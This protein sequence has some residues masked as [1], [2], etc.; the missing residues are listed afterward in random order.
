[1]VSHLTKADFEATL[2]RQLD[3]QQGQ[4]R[5]PLQAIPLHTWARIGLGS[6]FTERSTLGMPAAG[7]H[8]VLEQPCISIDAQVQSPT[9]L[10]ILHLTDLHLRA[11]RGLI[12]RLIPIISELDYDLALLGGD[13][14]DTMGGRQRAIELMRH[15]EAPLGCFAVLGNHDRFRYTYPDSWRAKARTRRGMPTRP[16]IRIPL[17]GFVEQMQGAGVRLLINES[18]AVALPAGEIWLLGVDDR[19]SGFDDLAAAAHNV[20]SGATRIMVSHS[21]DVWLDAAAAGVS[22]VLA[23]HTHGGQVLLPKIGALIKRTAMPLNP[24]CGHFRIGDS[25]LYVSRGTGHSLPLR[26]NCP[27]ELTLIDLRL[28]PL[29]TRGDAPGDGS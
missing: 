15:I 3:A 2:R 4:A 19:A 5:A 23:G 11:G 7:R 8:L 6:A 9:S 16:G 17:D 22:L 10:R 1:V 14:A 24:P 20:P 27:P 26:I 28:E 21:P 12:D 18:V 25:Q 29:R 13:Y